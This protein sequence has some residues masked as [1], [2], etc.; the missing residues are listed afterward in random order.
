MQTSKPTWA[1]PHTYVLLF[2]LIVLFAVL[3][4][5]V[6]SGAF[7]R[8]QVEIADGYVANTVVPGTYQP[9]DKVSAD[10]D[11]RQGLFDILSAPAKG[12]VHAA[13]VIAFVLV[14]GG[15]IGIVLFLISL[16]INVTASSFVFKQTKRSE[17]IL[18]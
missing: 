15:A 12:I 16:I 14:V 17:K 4:W 18:S 11:L 13:D 1:L 3:T 9:I 2:L 6:P 10:A 8:E 5:I 7:D